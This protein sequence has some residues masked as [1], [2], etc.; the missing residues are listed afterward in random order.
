VTQQ[1]FATS[2]AVRKYI[3]E[4]AG[5]GLTDAEQRQR[6]ATLAE[7]CNFVG[8]TPDQMLDEIFDVETQKY[9][10]RNFYSDR[11]KEFSAQISGTWS[12]R[13]ARGNVI[14]GFFIAN[15]RRLP[16]EKPDWL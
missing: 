5:K 8:R 2:P 14:R 16:N 11:V 10:Q 1:A 15:G 4:L 12:A 9:K 3:E 6:L 7:F 13:T